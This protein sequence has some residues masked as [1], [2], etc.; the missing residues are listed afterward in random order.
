[1]VSRIIPSSQKLPSMTRWLEE[2]LFAMPPKGRQGI[3]ISGDLAFGFTDDRGT[4]KGN[5]DRLAVVYC[6][7]KAQSGERWLFAGVCDG[8]G[9]E[10]SGEVAA[11]IA[12]S[13]VIS[14]LCVGEIGTPEERLVNAIHRAHVEV[15][16]RL[17]KR[18]ATTFAG[19]LITEQGVVSIG[20]VGDSR[21]YLVSGDGV[22][23]LTQDDTLAEMLRRQ[24]PNSINQQVQDAIK[25]LQPRW[26][27]SL[28]Q[29][30]GSDLPLKPQ[31]Y[32]LPNI[33]VGEGCLLCTDGVWK[34]LEDVLEKTVQTSIGRMDLARRLLTLTDHLGATDNATA[35][36]LPELTKIV[37]WLRSTH[38]SYEF[39][40]VHVV[41]PGETAV[42]P[43]SLFSHRPEV[44]VQP[45]I[46]PVDSTEGAWDGPRT[47]ASKPKRKVKQSK[48]EKNR[49]R[50]NE[51]VD[52]QQ[53]TISE[54]P[55][56]DESSAAAPVP[57]K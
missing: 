42:V 16:Q 14:H 3:K 12:L 46:K 30:L 36:V 29:A 23:K 47:T 22:K 35:I 20:S 31:T 19:L 10:A 38:R 5:Q 53:M 8:V 40:L 56:D 52:G 26:Q 15:Q 13:E 18:S 2:A 1:M 25:A 32:S 51:Q 33:A 54:G 21:I 37:Q 49:T 48:N 27:D 44:P 34:S 43:W 7:D 9:G 6:L 41:L 45:Q 28:G 11:S 39:G 57:K 50:K 4:E 17:Q 55:K 24:A